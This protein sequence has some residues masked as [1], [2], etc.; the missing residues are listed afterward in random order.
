MEDMDQSRELEKVCLLL[1]RACLALVSVIEIVFV[2]RTAWLV[3]ILDTLASLETLA[4]PQVP[5]R[6]IRH[7]PLPFANFIWT[8][9]NS[10]EWRKHIMTYE[11]IGTTLDEAMHCLSRPLGPGSESKLFTTTIGPYAR[12]I[13]CLTMLRGLVEYGQGKP[14]GGYVTRRWV[15]PRPADPRPQSFDEIHT[16]VINSYT[17]MLDFV[18]ISLLLLLAPNSHS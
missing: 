14:K 8:A 3:Y 7:I 11:A 12:H 17:T 4:V 10:E 6:D 13:L 16:H 1:S 9:P 15:L 18:R 2:G 5:T